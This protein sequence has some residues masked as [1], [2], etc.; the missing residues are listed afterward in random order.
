MIGSWD[1]DLCQIFF[2]IIPIFL[3]LLPYKLSHL[4]NKLPPAPF[5]NSRKRLRRA[6]VADPNADLE[7]QGELEINS[8]SMKRH[9]YM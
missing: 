2:F 1:E 6:V 5:F 7:N 3:L 9:N 8:S 4:Q